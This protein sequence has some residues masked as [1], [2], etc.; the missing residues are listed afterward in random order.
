MKVLPLRLS[1][2]LSIRPARDRD[3][4]F[5][6]YLYHTTR[7][8]LRQ[9]EATP[10]FIESLIQQQQRAQTV[11]YGDQFPNAMYFIVE[12]QGARIGR[13]VLDFDLD[14]IRVVDIAMLPEAQGLGYGTEILRVL[15]QAA[16]S[17]CA[18][19]VLSVSRQNIIA[20]RLYEQEGFQ[21][22]ERHEIYDHMTWYPIYA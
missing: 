2:A 18:P 5:I 9:I 12:K 8:D 10:G 1:G 15:K 3:R 20:R 4:P 14:E 13:I 17:A 22:C 21:V 19:L 11:G 7:D 16:T 6:E